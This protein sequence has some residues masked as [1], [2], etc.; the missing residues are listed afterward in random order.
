MDK[1]MLAPLR[2]VME[3]FILAD[4]REII[5]IRPALEK[6]PTGGWRRAAWGPLPAQQMRLVPYKRRLSDLVKVMANGEIPNIPYVLVCLWD[7]DIERFDEFV[8]DGA[9][10]RVEGLEPHT[11]VETYTDRKVA[12]LTVL[13]KAGVQWIGEPP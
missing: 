4:S 10:Y 11:A 1:K 5:L 7:A 2:R 9:Y 6:T 12:Q 3:E 8:L 13:D